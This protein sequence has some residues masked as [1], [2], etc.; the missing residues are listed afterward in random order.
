MDYLKDDLLGFGKSNGLIGPSPMTFLTGFL[1]IEVTFLRNGL[2]GSLCE[3]N[4]SLLS[5]LGGR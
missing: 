4:L 2:T 5:E 1:P 3:I